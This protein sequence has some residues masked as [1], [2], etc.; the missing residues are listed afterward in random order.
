MSYMPKF[1][2]L[3]NKF[4]IKI[5]RYD[6][7]TR[8]ILPKPIADF[9]EPVGG[10]FYYDRKN[11]SIV[12]WLPDSESKR[13]MIEKMYYSIKMKQGEEKLVK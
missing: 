6:N 1:N 4:Q 7:K 12:F 9:E 8:L 3:A 2:K 11:R 10:G 13:R 5:R